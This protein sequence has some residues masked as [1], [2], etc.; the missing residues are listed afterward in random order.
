MGSNTITYYYIYLKCNMENEYKGMILH[1]NK[2]IT[3]AK[4]NMN[5]TVVSYHSGGGDRRSWAIYGEIR[6]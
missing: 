5:L 4:C 2:N 6:F 1:A 3:G